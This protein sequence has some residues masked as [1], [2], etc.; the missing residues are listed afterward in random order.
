MRWALSGAALALSAGV[1]LAGDPYIV[2]K[3]PVGA[4]A[5]DAVTAKSRALE[6]GHKRAFRSLMKRLLPVTR[7]KDIPKPSLDQIENLVDGFAVRDEKNSRTEYLAVLDFRFRRRAVQQLMADHGLLAV[8]EVAKPI[9]LIPLFGPLAAASNAESDGASSTKAGLD[10]SRGLR[11]WRG[12]WTGLDLVNSV[13]PLTVANVSPNVAPSVL[14]GVVEGDGGALR[15][16]LDEYQTPRLITAHASPS[17]DGKKLVVRLSGVDEV[18]TFLLERTYPID[19]EDITFTAETAAVICLGI[20]EGRWK[21]VNAS[22][23]ASR[24]AQP[25][26]GAWVPEG[27]RVAAAQGQSGAQSVRMLV[28]FN[29]LAEWQQIQAQMRRVPGL[30]R[31]NTGTL[32]PRGAEVSARYPGGMNSLAPQLARLGLTVGI[33]DG[34]WVVRRH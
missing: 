21:S 31:F 16:A 30:G 13:T 22:E 10:P 4:V 12:A 3:Y 8:D 26:D 23:A 19:P 28:R 9:V 1:A 27:D 32:S 6:S 11:I 7:Y 34:I 15:V 33:E 2:A 5:R 29:G 18:G 20:I 24:P 25:S 17:E 14:S